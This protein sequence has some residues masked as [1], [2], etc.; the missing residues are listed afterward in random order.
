[1]APH[2]LRLLSRLPSERKLP[3]A[4]SK[5]W[6]LQ[7]PTSSGV[8]LLHAPRQGHM[9]RS[10]L[11]RRAGLAGKVTS[12]ER[13]TLRAYWILCGLRDLPNAGLRRL[14]DV[15]LVLLRHLSHTMLLPVAYTRALGIPP[16]RRLFRHMCIQLF[17][18][19]RKRM[20]RL[21]FPPAPRSDF[22]RPSSRTRTT[23]TTTTATASMT[24]SSL[25]STTAFLAPRLGRRRALPLS[26]LT[27]AL[28]EPGV[29]CFECSMN[30][31]TNKV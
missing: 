31:K 1:M 27:L 2:S 21:L 12:L 28:Y 6:L 3:G 22:S 26:E 17:L 16:S 25:S 14:V 4:L 7:S 15:Q 10:P 13:A 19:R 30:K 24:T 20:L 23:G 8:Q 5:Q 9:P 11:E 18:F 29:L